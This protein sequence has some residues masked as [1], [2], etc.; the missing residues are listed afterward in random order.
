VDADLGGLGPALGIPGMSGRATLVAEARGR[1]EA[2]EV[3]GAVRAQRIEVRGATVRDVEIP[4]RLSRST[5]RI[6][7]AR[8]TL[9]ASRV[10]ADARATWKGTGAPT[11]DSLARDARVTV[12]VRVPTARLEDLAPLLPSALRGRGELALAARAEGT[13][14]EW[15]G[16][17]TLTSASV[18]LPAGPLRQLGAAFVI[19]Q[20]RVTLTD[21]RVDAFGVPTRATGDWAWAGGGSAKATLGPASLAGLAMTPAGMALRGTGRATIEAAVRPPLDV[22]GTVH[23]DLDDVAIGK[24]V[25]GRGQVDVSARDS[26]VRAEVQFSEP[27]LR[28]SASGRVDPGGTLTADVAAPG[29]DLGY[30]LRAL[31][32]PGE[33]TGTLSARAM[34]RVPLGA[35]GGGD[36]VLVIDPLRLV[37]AS[38]AWENAR[39]LE[40]RWARGAVSVSPFQLGA[41]EGELTGSGGVAADGRLEARLTARVPLAM[42]AGMRPEIRETGGV[43]DLALRAAGTPGAPIFTGEGAIHRG[44]VLLRDRPETLR[45]LEAQVSLSRQ[46]VHLRDATGSIGG[47][48]VR[49]QGDLALTGW[50]PGGYRVRLQARNVAVGQIEG[51]SSAWDADLDLSGLAREAQLQGRARLVRGLYN[52]ELSILGLVMSPGRA[53]AADATGPDIGLSVRIELGDNL[54]VRNRVA[55]LR[56]NG[57][58][59]VQGTAARPVV[60]GSIE[61]R[62]GRIVFRSRDWTVTSATV[63]FADPRRLD[64]YLDV[65]AASRIGAY[66][67]NMQI[68]GPVSNIAVRFSSTPRLSQNDLLSLVAFGA[69]GADIRE[70]PATVLLGEAGKLVARSV[71]GIEPGEAGFSISTGSST[72]TVNEQRGFPGEERTPITPGQS[73]PGGRKEKVRLEYQLLTPIFLSAEYDRDGGYGADVIFRF[74]FR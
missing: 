64:P 31:D 4:F 28:L 48:R 56:A 20:T 37:V 50:H 23:A 40:I 1:G 26:V 27:R 3:T 44:S 69:T 74:R 18:E 52:R 66:E 72:S 73:T 59:T 21:L 29:I 13:P 32:P 51:F 38:E 8:A 43:L 63:R 14:L 10:S 61:S 30:V 57:V 41:R 7:R 68:T 60:F 70:S 47:G 49:A 54:V 42:L 53:P 9:G 71:L 33:I 6:E 2:V 25:L 39:P 34:V 62:D 65:L 24:V 5:A 15:R 35:P 36:G 17:G 45:D 58:L 11:A 16:S 12:D 67:V 46:G 19:D 22:S 55:D